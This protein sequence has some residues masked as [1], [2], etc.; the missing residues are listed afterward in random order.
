MKTSDYLPDSLDT[1]DMESLN[2][3][4]ETLQNLGKLR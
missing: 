1:S 3:A 4:L 2:T